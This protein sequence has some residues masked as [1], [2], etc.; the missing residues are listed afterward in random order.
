L[1]EER[2]QI[3]GWKVCTRSSKLRNHLSLPFDQ[4]FAMKRKGGKRKVRRREL[5]SETDKENLVNY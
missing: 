3:E 5:A 1:F 2:K 4:S